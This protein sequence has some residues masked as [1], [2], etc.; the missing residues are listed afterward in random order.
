VAPD[1][2]RRACGGRLGGEQPVLIQQVS[3]GDPTDAATRL[4]EKIAPRPE[5]SCFHGDYLI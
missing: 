1:R 3:Q 2:F 4:E 5:V